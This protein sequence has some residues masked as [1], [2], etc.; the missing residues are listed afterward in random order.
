MENLSD[1]D[2]IHNTVKDLIKTSNQELLVIL[3]TV[4]TFYR[5]EREG[6]IRALKEETEH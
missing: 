3:P 2:K 4:N 1:P 6:I 5:Y